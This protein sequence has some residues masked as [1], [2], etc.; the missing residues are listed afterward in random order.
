ME[1]TI[2]AELEDP[3]LSEVQRKVL[4][5]A[6]KHWEG[7]TVFVAH[8]QVPMDNNA[9]NGR[10]APLPWAGT[11]TTAAV[12]SGAAALPRSA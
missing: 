10:C 12:P 4:Q 2:T 5:S 1:E 7:L 8:P 9:A 6:K 11:I 3:A